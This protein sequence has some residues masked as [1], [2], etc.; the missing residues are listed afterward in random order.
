MASY[1][2]HPMREILT[3]VQCYSKWG[4]DV[5]R[6]TFEDGELFQRYMDYLRKA[7]ITACRDSGAA[8]V[9]DATTLY[10]KEEQGGKDL[11]GLSLDQVRK[12]HMEWIATQTRSDTEIDVSPIRQHCFMLVNYEVLERFRVAEEQLAKKNK[13]PTYFMEGVVATMCLAWE[14]DDPDDSECMWQYVQADALADLF[15]RV[16]NETGWWFDAFAR[17]PNTYGEGA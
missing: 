5:Y 3:A 12:H 17:P 14:P 8:D 15:H 9:A 11:N 1:W 16:S 4:F 2:A 10:I 7:M 6:T 13:E